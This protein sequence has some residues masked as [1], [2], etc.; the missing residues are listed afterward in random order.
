MSEAQEL[1]GGDALRVDAEQSGVA[2]AIEAM[3]VLHEPKAID[4]TDVS[5][6]ESVRL[7]AVPSGMRLVDVTPMLDARQAG[8]KRVKGKATAETLAGFVALVNHHDNGNVKIF[9][10]SA[11]PRLQAVIDYHGDS[12]G[13]CEHKILYSFPLSEA[14]KAW[15]ELGK[16]RAHRDFVASLNDRRFDLADP[17]DIEIPAEGISRD[18]VNSEGMRRGLTKAE[19]AALNASDVFAS[20]SKLLNAVEDLHCSSTRAWQEV[21]RP[22][23]GLEMHYREEGRVEG[24]SAC[25]ELFL[26]EIPAFTGDAKVVL[27]ARIKARVGDK[28]LE[29][30]AELI[31]I[32]RI[33]AEAF[34]AAQT[35]VADDTG[36]EVIPGSPEA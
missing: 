20:P 30:S 11:G 34:E 24:H 5:S 32:P 10:E 26:V 36:V 18:V 6:R 3:R 22:W 1:K 14:A 35:R 15:G 27:P 21:K 13:W 33:I 28:G 4:V 16:W 9:A 23:G 31:G 25:P 29:L 12:P 17:E 8:P 19:R 7:M 2:A